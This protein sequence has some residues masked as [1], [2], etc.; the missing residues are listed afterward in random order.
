MLILDYYQFYTITTTRFVGTILIDLSEAY[1][2][3]PHNPLIAKL[4]VYGSNY[5]SLT[6]MLDYLTSR[7]QRT[8]IGTSYSNLTEIFR[9]IPQGSVLGSLM[10]TIFSNDIFFF[11]ENSVKIKYVEKFVVLLMIIL[12]FHV[13]TSTPSER[14]LDL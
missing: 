4:E 5:N 1:D 2:C 14:G 11:V 13:K 8:K 7:K 6:F 12:Y 9:G 10:F 3:L